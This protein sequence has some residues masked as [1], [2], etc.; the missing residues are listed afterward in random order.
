MKIRTSVNLFLVTT[1]VIAVCGA[2]AFSVMQA[3]AYIENNFYK[4]VPFMLDASSS[5]LQTNLTVGLAL[6]Q[7]LAEEPY[8]IDWFE[9][10]EKDEKTGT[11]VIDK[12]LKLSK[13]EQFSTC[14]AASKLT[15]G[16]YVVDNNKQIKKDVL[17]EADDSWF[18]TMLKNPQTLFCSVDYNRTLNEINF[19]FDIKIFNSAGEAIGFAG[20]AVDLQKAV[21]KINK[22]LPSPQSWIGVI[23]NTDTISLCSN[24]DFTNKKINTVTGTLS[25]LTGYSNLQYYDDDLLGR[26]IIVKKQLSDLPYYTIMAVPV[27]DFIPPILSILGYSLLW[28]A[29]LLILMIII[30]QFMLSYLFGRF[31]KLHTIFDK[32]AEGDFTVQAAVH[33]DELGSIALSMNNAIEKIRASFSVITDTAKN[34]QSVSQTL[35]TRML[36]SAAALNQITGNI[37]N[38]KDRVMVQHTEVNETAAKIDAITQTMSSLDF[39]IDNQAKSIS[40]SSLSIEEIIKNI[41][42][43]Q[44]RAEKNLQ[45]IKTLEKTTHTGKETVAMVVEVTK[46]VT[47]QSEG[48][49]D[50]ITVIQNTASQTN[51]LAMNA[52]IEAAHAGEA[53]KGFAVVADEIR[54]LAEE[55]G[56]QGTSITKVLEELKH[57]IESLNGAGPLVAE[58]FEKISAMMDFIYRQEDGMI[59]TMKEQ[60]Q[61]GEEVLNVIN[62]MN[63]ITSKVKTDSNEILSEATDISAG[64][65]K[66]ANLSEVIT[67]SMAEMATGIAE[68]NNA[69]K[70]VNTI[71]I[72]N[73]KNAAS[74]T[75]EIGKFKV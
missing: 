9:A 39:H 50:A 41:Q 60:M 40:G 36:D 70:E 31:I 43:L 20:M 66:L 63:T 68:V 22:S 11:H 30:N 24:V 42:T 29:V 51:L 62:G 59:R 46:V 33:S 23:D 19:W 14:F 48:L 58:Q 54:K 44:E 75:G 55:S 17:T 25:D 35:S 64:I 3:R 38:V 16:Y 73:Q 57:K 12:M 2:L 52:A 74:V 6:S 37:E 28:T 5:E 53:G 49:L 8:L 1:L 13:D 56:A 72:N 61:G 18:F 4:T 32:V 27:K 45:S 10:Y 21:A 69:M 15:G 34:M 7:D 67:Q 65:R 71:A 47:E 26:V